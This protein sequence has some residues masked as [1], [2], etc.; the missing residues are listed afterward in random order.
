M[1]D[2]YIEDSSGSMRPQLT[3]E[4]VSALLKVLIIG[5]AQMEPPVK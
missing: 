5:G 1:V 3:A 4:E 2:L